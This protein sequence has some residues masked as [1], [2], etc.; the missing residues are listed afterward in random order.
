MCVRGG[1]IQIDDF[2]ITSKY[3]STRT[4]NTFPDNKNW[5]NMLFHRYISARQEDNKQG[6]K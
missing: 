2:C 5:E 4:S 1:E 6:E 3:T